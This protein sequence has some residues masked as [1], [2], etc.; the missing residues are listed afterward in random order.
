MAFWL[1]LKAYSYISSKLDCF[2]S[3][4]LI[5]YY[6]IDVFTIRHTVKQNENSAYQKILKHISNVKTSIS[7][8]R[9]EIAMVGKVEYKISIE[10]KSLDERQPLLMHAS[11]LETLQT[12]LDSNKNSTATH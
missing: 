3:R 5:F 1:P 7:N 11:P 10:N 2:G 4:V 8:E 9:A 12:L 6:L